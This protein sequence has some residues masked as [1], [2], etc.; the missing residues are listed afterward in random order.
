MTLISGKPAK[1]LSE[2]EISHLILLGIIIF[3]CWLR[4]MPAKLAG[5]P[6]NDG[7]MF[8]TMIRDL[9]H[10]GYSLPIFTTYNNQNIPF[11]Y[12]PLPFFIAGMAA[13]FLHASDLSVLLWLPAII[14]IL[15]IPAFLLLANAILKSRLKSAVATIFF[16]LTPLSMDWYLMGGGLT[17]GIGQLFLILTSYYTFQLFNNRTTRS[18]ILTIICGALVVLSHPESALLTL[19]STAIIWIFSSRSKRTIF[20]VFLVCAGVTLICGPWL[21]YVLRLH[22][23]TP[24]I[25]AMQTNGNSLFLWT[26]LFSFDF[27]Q[28][29]GLQILGF[30]GLIGLF[31]KLGQ[32]KYFLPAW[33]IVPFFINPRSSSRAAIIPLA[34]LAAISLLDVILPAI[35]GKPG[36]KFRRRYL[37]T[38]LFLG[39]LLSYLLFNAFTLDLKLA[40]NRLGN[41][42]QDAMAWIR[43]NTPNN[44]K[45]IIITG[46]SQMMRD[47]VQEW[48]PTI[49]E[50]RSQTTL[51][52]LEWVWGPKFIDSI[53]SYQG[54]IN[55]ILQDIAC[56]KNQTARLGIS[57]DHVYI[58][59]VADENC[60]ETEI[61]QL[62]QAL[63]KELR[64]STEFRLAY[65]NETTAIFKK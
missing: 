20:D 5:F 51:Q 29:T 55:C 30:L 41:S 52:G 28:E 2:N 9:R 47:P 10:N 25:N 50:R 27:A 11:S 49:T 32:N 31:V 48:F 37:V 3:G 6:I 61:C 15:L 18:L 38:S 60:P 63:I 42:D 40:N 43:Q 59:K 34:I 39:Y 8:I 24:F 14:N 58:K 54:L 22:G 36:Q 45:F 4:I 64:N 53:L 12:P 57:Y 35:H 17:R 44:S 65:E 62:E 19:T 7:G 26:A 23:L 21:F 46:E 16:A 13:D 1:S 56:I 33:L